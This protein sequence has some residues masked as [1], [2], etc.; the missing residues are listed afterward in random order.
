METNEILKELSD[1]VTTFKKENEKLLN[2]ANEAAKAAKQIADEYAEKVKQLNTDLAA[3]DATILQIQE[4][5]K[6][7]KAKSG[8]IGN[9]LAPV[10][11]SVETLIAKSFESDDAKEV[12]KAGKPGTWLTEPLKSKTK[13]RAKD[14]GTFTLSNNL[15][16]SI[17]NVGVP[18]WS[19][20]IWGRGYDDMH[21]RDLFRVID[22]ATGTYVFYQGNTPPGEGSV[23]EVQPAG[24]KPKIDKDLTL[25]KVTAVYRAGIFDVA[26]EALQDLPMLQSYVN[27]ELVND[28]LDVE[29]FDHFTSL[30][31]AASGDSTVPGGLSHAIQKIVYLLA[32]Q[33]K[34]KYRADRIIIKPLKWAEIALTKPNDFSLPNIVTVTPSGAVAIAGVPVAVVNTDALADTQVLVGDSRKAGL[35]QVVGEGLQLELF[36]Q[37]DKAVYN[38]IVTLRVEART[39]EITFRPDAF[40]KATI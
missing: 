11:D 20:D 25:Q 6:E 30:L 10:A 29:T 3:K 23:A 18:T 39:E 24:T 22:S 13:F 34:A 21:F 1:K 38:N 26:K 28:Y 27:E 14:A 17:S 37:H 4:S 19:Q 40:I 8:H 31:A 35:I 32:N 36:K 2:E 12:L 5:V 15:T 9:P 16:Q 7:L 33:R